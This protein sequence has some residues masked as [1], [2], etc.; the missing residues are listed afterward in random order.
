MILESKSFVLC[1]PRQIPSLA[2]LK[3]K[4]RRC[5]AKRTRNTWV[6]DRNA[7]ET[8]IRKV[9]MFSYQEPTNLTPGWMKL[10][11]DRFYEM[12]PP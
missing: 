6:F 12:Q 2:E 7:L 11:G 10:K 3:F 1:Q 9:F 8:R 4:G 5:G